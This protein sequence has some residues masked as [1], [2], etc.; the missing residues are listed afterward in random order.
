[1][2][3]LA[4][5]LSLVPR[6]LLLAIAAA[7]AATSCRLSVDF[8][9]QKLALATLQMEVAK[10]N[11]HAASMAASLQSS[12]VKAQNDA[13]AREI[14]LRAAA[15]AARSESDGLRNDLQAMR[16]SFAT[17]SRDS[18]IE[19]AAA[20]GDVLGQCA[21]QHQ[22][23]AERCDRHVNDLKTLIDAWPKVSDGT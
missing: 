17:A 11:A 8:D 10:A 23:L 19:R 1:M 21:I 3:A 22:S 7:F 5:L 2:S 12:V 18:A 4:G 14:P 20:I 15:A 16:A 9:A 13:K 6:W